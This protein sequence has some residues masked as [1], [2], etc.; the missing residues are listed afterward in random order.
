MAPSTRVKSIM[1]LTVSRPAQGWLPPSCAYRL[2]AEGSDLY[3]WHHLVSGDPDT[4]H[5]AGVS[6]RGRTVSEAG[7]ALEDYEDHLAAWPGENPMDD[8]A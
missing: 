5:Q 4:V 1:V 6:V 2:V 8:A 7:M 3:W